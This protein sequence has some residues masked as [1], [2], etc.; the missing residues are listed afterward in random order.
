MK[1]GIGDRE[2]FFN[3]KTKCM[4]LKNQ[5]YHTLGCCQY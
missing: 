5:Q 2:L 1:R 3:D 4:K